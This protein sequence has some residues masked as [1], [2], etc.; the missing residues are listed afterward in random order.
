MKREQ[1]AR[2]LALSSLLGEK[3]D[4]L[5]VGSQ[6][7]LGTMPETELPARQYYPSRLILL[8]STAMK[9]KPTE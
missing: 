1:L 6:A 4:V 5:V 8:S 9:K 2:L 7:I 3:A